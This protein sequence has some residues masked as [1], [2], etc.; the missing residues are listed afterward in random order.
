ML[1]KVNLLQIKEAI[2]KRRETVLHVKYNL[3]INKNVCTFFPIG[4]LAQGLEPKVSHIFNHI[5]L[6]SLKV[7]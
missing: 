3:I 1:N 6:K 5:N 7:S 2:Y 4:D